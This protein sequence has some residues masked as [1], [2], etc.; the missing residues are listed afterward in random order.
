MKRNVTLR[1]HTIPGYATHVV[2]FDADTNKRIVRTTE[3]RKPSDARA[4]AMTFA[5][6][7]RWTVVA[8]NWQ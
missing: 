4:T 5:A 6:H 3:Y 2:I 8:R 1:S 7:R